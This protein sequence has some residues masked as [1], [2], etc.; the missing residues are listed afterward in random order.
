MPVAIAAPITN[1]VQ[2][3]PISH[4]ECLV[5]EDQEKTRADA[6]T[7]TKKEMDTGG[8]PCQQRQAA[9]RRGDPHDPKIVTDKVL[10]R[11]ALEPKWLDWI[12]VYIYVYPQV[13]PLCP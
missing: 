11:Q 7:M 8:G 9:C 2:C 4:F 3:A 1:T 6:V 13:G 10:A 12:Y 5:I